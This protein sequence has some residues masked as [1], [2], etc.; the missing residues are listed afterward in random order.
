MTEPRFIPKKTS[1]KIDL[2]FI[3]DTLTGSLVHVKNGLKLRSFNTLKA[4]QKACD[5]LE[6]R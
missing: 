1:A 5:K 4:C 6:N 3:R 2:W